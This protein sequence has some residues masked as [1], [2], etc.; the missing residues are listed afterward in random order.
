MQQESASE[1]E[2]DAITSAPPTGDGGCGGQTDNSFRTSLGTRTRNAPS[3]WLTRFVILRLVGLVYFVAFLV[4]A[5]Q[6]IPLI[7]QSGL[8]PA[9]T[10][11]HRIESHF[12][13]RLAAL[14]QAPSIFIFTHDSIGVGEDGPTHQPIEQLASLRAMPNMIVLRPADA[15]EVVEAYK[16]LMQLRHSPATLVLRAVGHHLG[17]PARNATAI[18]RQDGTS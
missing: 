12:G 11:L 4:A 2:G 3:Y 18:G 1:H 13:S 10:F 15:N 9:E 6:I 16:V 14:M 8:L 7:G 5:R 17:M